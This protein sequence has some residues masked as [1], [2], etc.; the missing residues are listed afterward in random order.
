[1]NNLGNIPVSFLPGTRKVVLVDPLWSISQATPAEL[2]TVALLV[3]T[4]P[5]CF[6]HHQVEEALVLLLTYEGNKP[7]DYQEKIMYI[8]FLVQ[9]KVKN[10]RQFFHLDRWT[11]RPSFQKQMEIME[12]LMAQHACL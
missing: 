10:W 4:F 12:G 1:M 11:D 2:Q 6:L 9:Q 5:E 3:R 7:S 8:L